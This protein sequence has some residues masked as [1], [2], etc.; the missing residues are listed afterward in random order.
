M[1]I[2][3]K[4]LQLIPGSSDRSMDQEL[5]IFNLDSPKQAFTPLPHRHK[6]NH[7][8]PQDLQLANNHSRPLD[9]FFFMVT[10]TTYVDESAPKILN[11]INL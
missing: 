1:N 4:N 9:S 10:L 5:D 8:Q 3:M 2:L 6:Y 11:W 7:P